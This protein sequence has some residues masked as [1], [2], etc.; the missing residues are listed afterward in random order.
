MNREY[1]KMLSRSVDS[2]HCR[3]LLNYLNKEKDLSTTDL[4]RLGKPYDL[5]ADVL[6]EKG[7]IFGVPLMV[8]TQLGQ[9][10]VNF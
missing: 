3:Q 5:A 7:L 9:D 4:R 1:V 10:V 6:V 8:L 2:D